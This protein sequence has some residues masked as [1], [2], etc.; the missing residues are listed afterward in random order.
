MFYLTVNQRDKRRIDLSLAKT[1]QTSHFLASG[2]LS[3]RQPSLKIL[4]LLA[5]DAD[6]KS[7]RW[8]LVITG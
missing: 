2:H 6:L 4:R 8:R 7:L 1:S 3:L 5:I